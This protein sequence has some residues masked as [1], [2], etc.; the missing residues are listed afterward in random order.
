MVEKIL[1]VDDEQAIRDVL[2]TFL[3]KAGYPVIVA[4]NGMEAIRQAES[5]TPHL[6]ILDARMPDLDGVETCLR[7]RSQERTRS[8]PI[9]LATG[10]KHVLLEALD[11]G[12][13][14]FV[15]KPVRLAELLVRIRSMLRVRHVEDGIERAM[16][17]TQE[18]RRTLP[19]RQ[20]DQEGSTA[21]AMA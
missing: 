9:I 3:E 7:L 12:V 21:L 10:F 18:L 17:Y 19:S 5:E 14:D 4:S 1:V 2:K 8:I 13:D 20:F 11:A 16:A 6:I 15:M